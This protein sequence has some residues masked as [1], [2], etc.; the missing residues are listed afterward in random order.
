MLHTSI[1]YGLL[2][3]LAIAL[4]VAV[5]TDLKRR[6]IDNW[7]NAAIAIGAP[8]FWWA[9]GLAWWPDIALH[10]GVALAAFAVAAGL[11][12]TPASA[13]LADTVDKTMSGNE[14]DTRIVISE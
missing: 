11:C 10:L 7:L 3:L 14:A 1:Y 4:L 2:A 12:F 6:E 9:G 8:A 13:L 5:V